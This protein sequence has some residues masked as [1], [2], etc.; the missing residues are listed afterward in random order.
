MKRKVKEY[1]ENKFSADLDPG[2]N[3]EGAN[4]RSISVVKSEQLC[5]DVSEQEILEAIIQCETKIHDPNNYNFHFVK[6]NQE[7]IRCDVIEVIQCFQYSRYILRGCNASF[8]YIS[9]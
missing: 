9:A 7:I 1:F 3:L 8:F 4:F 6:S 5:R 2:L